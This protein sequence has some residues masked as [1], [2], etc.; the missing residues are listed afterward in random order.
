MPA[1]IKVFPQLSLVALGCAGISPYPAGTLSLLILMLLPSHYF[2]LSIKSSP[3]CT[4]YSEE[5]VCNFHRVLYVCSSHSYHKNLLLSQLRFL[6]IFLPILL[7][8]RPPH[9]IIN[10]GC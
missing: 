7:N 10:A 9:V 1:G 4:I 3:L 5:F 2:L 8:S 6:V